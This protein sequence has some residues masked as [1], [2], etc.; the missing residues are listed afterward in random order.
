MELMRET[1]SE[2]S[3][4]KEL[5]APRKIE[6]CNAKIDS[7]TCPKCQKGWLV[8]RRGK[9]GRFMACSAF[10]NCD[11]TQNKEKYS[12]QINNEI[13]ENLRRAYS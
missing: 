5:I 9:F 1:G 6:Y 8:E 11:F 13:I 2:L 7:F 3:D 4:A 10:P 12:E